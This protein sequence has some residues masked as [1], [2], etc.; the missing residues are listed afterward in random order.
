VHLMAVC[1]IGVYLM[2]VHLTGV[3]LTGVH[4]MAVDL[5][6]CTFQSICSM[7]PASSFWVF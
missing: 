7:I 3:C 5:M 1:L 4:L 6:A 2:A